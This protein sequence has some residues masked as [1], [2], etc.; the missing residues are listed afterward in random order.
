M[1]PPAILHMQLQGVKLA[2]TN[3]SL[4]ALLNIF[5]N[6]TGLSTQEESDAA[7][8]PL[9]EA[10]R[11]A[12]G[13]SIARA[14][15]FLQTAMSCTTFAGLLATFSADLAAQARRSAIQDIMERTGCEMKYAERA[16]DESS[17]KNL[18]ALDEAARKFASNASKDDFN[19]GGGG[20]LGGGPR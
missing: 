20:G 16:Y 11:Q 17:T 2:N 18:D 13:C 5:F 15:Q 7:I 1:R 12:T 4:D 14:R 6:S 9:C 8:G 10:L 19:Y 3:A